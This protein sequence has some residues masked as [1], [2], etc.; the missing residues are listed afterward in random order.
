MAVY[1]SVLFVFLIAQ[2]AALLILSL[3]LPT[4]LRNCIVKV[5]DKFLYKSSQVKTILVVMNFIVLS[6]FLDSYKR[7]NVKLPLSDSG[8]PL[9]PELLVTKAY[10]QRN[11]YISG[12]IL[13]YMICIPF[14]IRLI[15]KVVKVT[16]KRAT[17]TVSED[18]V[19]I[20]A[21]KSKLDGKIKSLE[22]LQ[23]QYENKKR[24]V[25]Q[26]KFSQGTEDIA[27]KKEK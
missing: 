20:T 15:S 18:T 10:H 21:L 5:Y 9:Q 4:L 27:T 19:M 8:I 14:M 16:S 1:L 17:S 2:M 24:F 11:V 23:K 12:F 13:Y 26:H 25:D 22:V 3:P 6:L 7:A